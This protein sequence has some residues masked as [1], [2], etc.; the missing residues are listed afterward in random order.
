[1]GR[2]E[3]VL[4]A[5]GRPLPPKSSSNQYAEFFSVD[6]IFQGQLGDCFMIAAIMGMTQNK[7]LLS[8]LMPIDNALRNN[9]RMGLFHFRLWN[10][11]SWYDV[12]VDDFLPADR[13]YN[14]VFT[15][16]MTFPNEFWIAL[17]EKA[18]AK[19]INNSK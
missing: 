5:S 14:L 18:V 16:N 9:M 12:V 3:F 15:R 1:L 10:L 4:D 13:Q 11:G 6:D 2:D 7:R 17:L 19:Y 8:W